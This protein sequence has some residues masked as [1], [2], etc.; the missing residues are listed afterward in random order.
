M[1]TPKITPDDQHLTNDVNI[2]DKDDPGVWLSTQLSSIDVTS[3]PQTFKR[4]LRR[5]CLFS[6][7]T[8]SPEDGTTGRVITVQKKRKTIRMRQINT[9]R[10]TCSKISRV[11]TGI[12]L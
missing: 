3:L 9:V 6:S 11:D 12:E 1:V 2:P 5:L 10:D 7:R 4:H 8:Q